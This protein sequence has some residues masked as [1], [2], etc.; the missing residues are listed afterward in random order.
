[1]VQAPFCTSATSVGPRPHFSGPRRLSVAVGIVADRAEPPDKAAGAGC[2]GREEETLRGIAKARS[3][4]RKRAKD[5]G[6]RDDRKNR[7]QDQI[8]ILADGDGITGW[9]LSVNSAR[10][11]RPSKVPVRLEGDADQRRD[12]VVELLASAASS[13]PPAGALAAAV[14]GGAPKTGAARASEKKQG[15]RCFGFTGWMERRWAPAAIPQR[16]ADSAAAHE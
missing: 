5:I 1:M 4:C 13:S 9:M 12:R 11:R 7:A 3:G 6:L 2:L 10:C 14:V 16:S 15:N 8:P